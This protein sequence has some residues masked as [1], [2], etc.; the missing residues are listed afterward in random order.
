M[1]YYK[2]DDLLNFGKNS[3]ISLREIYQFE[4]TYLEWL[5]INVPSF[6]IDIGSFELL[7]NPTPI[8][9]GFVSGS[10]Q[11]ENLVKNKNILD[12]IIK[13]DSVNATLNVNKIK[14]FISNNNLKV[15]PVQFKFSEEAHAVNENKEVI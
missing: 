11:L 13:S 10:K 9:T 8:S 5:I 15:K 14:E 4:P 7:P 1:N 6:K 3:G 2:P 12:L